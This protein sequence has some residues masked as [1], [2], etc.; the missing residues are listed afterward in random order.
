MEFAL[1]RKRKYSLDEWHRC[2]R[3]VVHFDKE[4]AMIQ[5]IFDSFNYGRPMEAYQCRYCNWFHI[6]G[7]RN[8][9]NA[10]GADAR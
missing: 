5:A 3:K 8:G 9:V 4:E 7:A 10:G 2:G 1:K 6:G